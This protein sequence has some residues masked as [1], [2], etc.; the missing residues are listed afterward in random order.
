M[1]KGY[2]NKGKG[3]GLCRQGPGRGCKSPVPA[4]EPSPANL[5]WSPKLASEGHLMLRVRQRALPS[6]LSGTS[7]EGDGSCDRVTGESGMKGRQSRAG[8]C[9]GTNRTAA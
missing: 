1:G 8:R 3:P 7:Q 9:R 2:P 6:C 4:S 5:T